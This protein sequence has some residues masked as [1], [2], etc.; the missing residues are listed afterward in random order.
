M[1]ERRHR[2]RSSLVPTELLPVSLRHQQ[3]EARPHC[4]SNTHCAALAADVYLA[5]SPNANQKSN[6]LSVTF[7]FK[8][9][10]QRSSSIIIVFFF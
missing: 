4:V 6:C 9:N 10:L 7:Q 3:Q 2:S 8:F 1:F 5:V